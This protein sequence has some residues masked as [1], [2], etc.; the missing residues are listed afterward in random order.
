MRAAVVLALLLLPVL[1]SPAGPATPDADGYFEIGLDYL[2]KGFFAHARSAFGES[3]ILAPGEPVPTVFLGIATCG[4]R[5][6]GP[7]CASL[8]RLGYR[9][10]PK[11]RGLRLDLTA[12][13]PSR[14]ALELIH[15]DYARRLARVSGKDA[16]RSL[17]SV[18]AFLEVH[19]RTPARA[20]SLAVLLKEHP[21]DPYALALAAGA[22][23][24]RRPADAR[25][26]S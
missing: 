24:P 16:R 15:R 17:L 21:K 26:E 23:S 19:D 7:V 10:L 2:R 20:P 25:G 4:E 8:L 14:K 12:L 18:L 3:L 5:R 13:L 9:R 22:R 1:P 6:P 11:D